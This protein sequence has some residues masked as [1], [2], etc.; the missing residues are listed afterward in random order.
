MPVAGFW[1]KRTALRWIDE[2]AAPDDY[3]EVHRFSWWSADA[4]G[5]R[6]AADPA[7]GGRGSDGR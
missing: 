1:R 6:T 4:A 5:Q 3:L 2:H 7:S